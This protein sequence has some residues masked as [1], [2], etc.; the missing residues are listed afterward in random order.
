MSTESQTKTTPRI[1]ALLQSGMI[2]AAIS[3]A[4]NLGNIPLQRL[5]STT[6]PKNG[7]YADAGSAIGALIPLL[8]FLP[9][10]ASI[11][12]T[13]YIA[14]FSG[15]GDAARLQGLLLGCRRFLFRLTLAGSVLTLIVIKPLSDYFHYSET[16]T[17]AVLINTLLTLWSSFATALCSGLGWFRRLA[18][19]GFLTMVL[20][21]FLVW[22]LTKIWAASEVVVLATALALLANL[23]LLYWR[24][25]IRLHGESISP[26]NQEFAHFFIV[27]AAFTIGSICFLQ[28]DLFVAQH[29]FLDDER[30][31]FTAAGNLARQLPSAVS[32]LLMVLFTSRTAQQAGGVV[33]DQLKLLGLS[34]VGLFCGAAGL[35]FMSTLALKIIGRY[36]PEA[37]AFLSPF[38]L[39]MVFVGLI[40]SLAFWVL[41]SRWLKTSILYGALG[42]GYWFVLLKVGKTPMAML[43]AMPV[44]AGI[45][46]IVLFIAW[47]IGMR[48]HR[49]PA[50]Q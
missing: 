28:G 31:P 46:F 13:H 27:S 48:Q 39:T 9:A 40:Q 37:A 19:I 7:D 36:S 26:W 21:I 2:F 1:S 33:R 44:A 15:Q 22:S 12:I 4:T 32:P 29:V 10:T 38:A 30:G 16:M 23:I 41:A 45:A 25:E 35:I 34:C 18:L 11:A 24:K 42:I 47:L 20:K 50:P 6:L 49:A 3:F 5:F 8:G 14:H 17:L 43:H